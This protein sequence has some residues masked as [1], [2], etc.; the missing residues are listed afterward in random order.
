MYSYNDEKYI[1]KAITFLSDCLKVSKNPKPV[2]L[3][4]IRM[5]NLLMSFRYEIPILIGALLHDLLEDTDCSYDMVKEKFGEEIANIVLAL[6]MNEELSNY[7]EKYISNF[8]KASCNKKALIVR[9]ADLI[10]NSSY[11]KL[12]ELKTQKNV[13]EKHHYFYTHFSEI[14]KKEPIWDLFSFNFSIEEK[15]EQI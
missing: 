15:N 3:H 5:M 2:L 11:I 14:L 10:D 6:T 9:C 8:K 7:T 1:E 4:S 13:K 12:A